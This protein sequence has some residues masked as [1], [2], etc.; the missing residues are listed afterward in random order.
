M[1]RQLEAKTQ[2]VCFPSSHS[3]QAADLW[4]SKVRLKWWGI[5][6]FA[7]SWEP[8]CAFGCRMRAM[9][10]FINTYVHVFVPFES[11]QISPLVVEQL[12]DFNKSV[13]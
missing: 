2:L 4:L 1:N 13:L 3:S 8:H 5:R 12:T 11:A 10:S 7:Y 6:A 9:A